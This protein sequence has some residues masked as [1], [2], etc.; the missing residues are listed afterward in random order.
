MLKQDVVWFLRGNPN[1]TSEELHSVA[2]Q[3]HR[4]ETAREGASGSDTQHSPT[5]ELSGML[6]LRM[7]TSM[8]LNMLYDF[9]ILNLLFIHTN[10]KDLHNIRYTL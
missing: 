6:H 2:T 8:N 10:C 1:F 9:H 4:A 3:Q 7:L 5:N